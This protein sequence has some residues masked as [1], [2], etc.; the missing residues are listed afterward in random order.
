MY[1]QKVKKPLGTL[2]SVPRGF[3]LLGIQSLM[4]FS[5][6]TPFRAGHPFSV[7]LGAGGCLRYGS[8][9]HCHQN[10]FHQA[11]DPAII[12]LITFLQSMRKVNR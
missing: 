7:P 2:A 5:E 10:C 4:P 9:G 1:S 12:V 3:D 11:F 6:P 8:D